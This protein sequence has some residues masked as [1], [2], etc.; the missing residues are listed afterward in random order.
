MVPEAFQAVQGPWVN[1]HISVWRNELELSAKP[2]LQRL[3]QEDGLEGIIA[4][5]TNPAH[6]KMCG[7]GHLHQNFSCFSWGCVMLD[8]LALPVSVFLM[9]LKWG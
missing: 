8:S 4:K 1:L 5:M 9:S 6:L 2:A 3:S 7:S